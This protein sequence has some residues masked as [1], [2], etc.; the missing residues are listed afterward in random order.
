MAR[1][2]TKSKGQPVSQS[3]ANTQQYVTQKPYKVKNFN[4]FVIY[5]TLDWQANLSQ[6]NFFLTGNGQNG[7]TQYDTNMTS[8]GQFP[9]GRDVVV[10]ALGFHL[11]FS[12]VGTAGNT[13]NVASIAAQTQAFYT[14]LENSYMEFVIQGRQFEF[15]TTGSLWLPEIAAVGSQENITPT[16]SE[17]TVRVGDYIKQGGYTLRQPIVLQNLV[18]FQFNMNVNLQNA[19]VTN[20]LAVLAPES[21]LPAR[22]RWQF[23]ANLRQG[24]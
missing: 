12:P 23:L 3:S 13:T 22:I 14:I 20:A 19:Q 2:H 21:V 7:K 9:L 11:M 16:L 6:Y 8:G 24:A 10:K 18:P 17:S 4:D 1:K 5:D 15:Q